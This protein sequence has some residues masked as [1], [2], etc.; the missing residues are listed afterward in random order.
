MRLIRRC[1]HRNSLLCPW[2]SNYGIVSQFCE[3]ASH[4]PIRRSRQWVLRRI[5]Q[6]RADKCPLLSASVTCPT[7]QNLNEQKGLGDDDDETNMKP[8]SG[9]AEWITHLQETNNHNSSSL[10]CS[11]K[12]V[13]S[14]CRIRCILCAVDWSDLP[15]RLSLLPVDKSHLRKL[16]M[17]KC[18]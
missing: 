11:E 7:V 16:S 8:N 1:V 17:T 4:S 18:W 10:L 6:K 5:T 2:K 14:F 13:E 3:N 9:L 12:H 15:I